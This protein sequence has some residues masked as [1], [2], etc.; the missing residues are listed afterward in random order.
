[1]A[2]SVIPTEQHMRIL[3]IEDDAKTAHALEQGLRETIGCA[4]EEDLS[5]L[6]DKPL[7]H[8]AVMNILHNAIRYS[9]PKSKIRI[10][11]FRRE[12]SV[13]IEI[14]DEGPGIAPEFQGK[15]FDRFF[16]VDK[17]RS[18][19]EGG[20]GLG[21]AIARFSAEQQ[22]GTVELE[23]AVGGGSRFRIVLPRQ[24]GIQ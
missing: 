22:S 5:P 20:A 7:L 24:V 8:Q 1:M 17:A 23:S 11:V 18:R 21:L 10:R 9:P 3:I 4:S 2:T 6:A 12:A 19:A 15:V 13:V 16:R 14:A